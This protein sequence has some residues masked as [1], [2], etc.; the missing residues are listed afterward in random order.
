MTSQIQIFN[1]P[2]FGNIRTVVEDAG[3]LFCGRDVTLALG[4]LNTSKAMADHCRGVTKRYIGVCTGQRSDGSD[5]FQVMEMSFLPESDIYRLICSSKL[6]SAERFEKWVFEEVLPSIRKHGA[7]MTPEMIEKTLTNPDF[8][9]GLCQRLKE[10]QEKARHLEAKTQADAPKVLFADAVSV[11]SSEILVGDLAKILNQNGVDIGQ[12]RLFK[13]LRED[14]FLMS[15]TGS[16]NMPT[17]RAMEMGL[18]RIK[19]TS[20]NK[21]DGSILITRTTK[22]TGRGQIY[23]I[24]YFLRG[25]E[26]A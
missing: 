19:E 8:I 26:A 25:K 4:Y 20:I 15:R 6:P 21:P 22:V 1:S 14:G 16:K 10:E 2:E 3:V 5:T 24:N 23:F 18:F 11:S 7:Y 13:R 17:Q 12:N 9:I